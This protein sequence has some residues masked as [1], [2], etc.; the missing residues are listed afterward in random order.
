MYN[1]H[2]SYSRRH[3]AIDSIT[4]QLLVEDSK[5]SESGRDCNLR[6]VYMRVLGRNK[7]T[8]IDFKFRDQIPNES[9]E[10]K[11]YCQNP[12]PLFLI[13]SRLD[14]I[15]I[16]LFQFQEYPYYFVVFK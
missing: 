14:T 9:S 4:N 16:I 7:Y 1:S 11:E 8:E 10:M 3:K 15:S 12:W 6:T 13:Q 5:I 2:Q